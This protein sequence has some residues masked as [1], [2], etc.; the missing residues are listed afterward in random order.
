M[1][2]QEQSL[3]HL[4]AK[5]KERLDDETAKSKD[6]GA[7]IKAALGQL[8]DEC[9]AHDETKVKQSNETAYRRENL[10]CCGIISASITCIAIL[11]RRFIKN[12]VLPLF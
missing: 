11:C 4:V 8:Q 6:L 5:L 12:F 3:R 1:R 10:S 2:E 9:S 7:T